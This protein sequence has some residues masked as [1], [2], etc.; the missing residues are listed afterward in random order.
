[1]QSTSV[2]WKMPILHD[3]CLAIHAERFAFPAGITS[4]H[5]MSSCVHTHTLACCTRTRTQ[6]YI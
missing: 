2:V 3:T 5:E 4:L 1:M 6:E